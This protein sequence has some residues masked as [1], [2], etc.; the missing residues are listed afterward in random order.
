[1]EKKLVT[2]LTT[3][4]VVVALVVV[5]GAAFWRAPYKSGS[6]QNGHQHDHSRVFFEK[7]LVCS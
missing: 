1:M 2:W 6:E 3:L 7:K 4:V 5:L